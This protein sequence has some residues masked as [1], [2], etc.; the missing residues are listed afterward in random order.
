[1]VAPR[2]DSSAPPASGVPARDTRV[3]HAPAFI[4]PFVGTYDTTT[5][6]GQYG[7]SGWTSPNVPFDPAS[8][9]VNGWFSF[10]L[11]L[12]WDGK[13]SPTSVR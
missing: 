3:E 8:R 7:L 4:A 5:G 11:T 12:T 1:M 9:E 2:H 13:P 6:G 10:G